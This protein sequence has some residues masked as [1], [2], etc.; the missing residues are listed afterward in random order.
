[1]VQ[2]NFFV[3]DSNN[4]KNVKPHMYGYSISKKGFLTDNYYKNLGYYEE[5][6]S[7]GAYVM[8]RINDNE[9]IINQDFHGSYGLYIYEE[10]NTKYFAMSNSF[11]LLEEY[12]AWKKYIS[13]NKDFSDNFI[14]SW[15]FTPSIYETMIKE[16]NRLFHQNL[17]SN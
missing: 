12:L 2:E 14:L 15:L 13:L 6:E 17:V 5:P 4:L 9:I 3:I 8:I 7:I 10:K 1:M 11:L 16:I